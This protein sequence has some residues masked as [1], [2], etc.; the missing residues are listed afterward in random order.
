LDDTVAEAVVFGTVL[1]LLGEPV[2]EELVE[3]ASVTIVPGVE[4]LLT[5][6]LTATELT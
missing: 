6:E 4:L 3:V 5:G 2:V 1:P